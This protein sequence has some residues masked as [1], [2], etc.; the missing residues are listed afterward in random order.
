[1]CRV[2]PNEGYSQ[3]PPESSTTFFVAIRS[4]QSFGPDAAVELAIF[5]E[6]IRWMQ[7][8]E[9]GAEAVTD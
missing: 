8:L 7:V 1:M 3:L 6:L 5:C 9:L 4:S 2:P